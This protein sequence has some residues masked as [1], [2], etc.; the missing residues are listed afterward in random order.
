MAVV[1]SQMDTNTC[2]VR[3][4]SNPRGYRIILY[5][6]YKNITSNQFKILYKDGGFVDDI[7]VNGGGSST[8]TNTV[9]QLNITISPHHAAQDIQGWSVHKRPSGITVFTFDVVNYR[10]NVPLCLHKQGISVH[11]CSYLSFYR[12]IQWIS[13]SGA[14]RFFVQ[15]AAQCPTHGG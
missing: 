11:L 6:D 8:V 7:S 12:H 1:V 13:V 5:F 3:V 2:V 14:Q 10:D 4:V 15:Q 9:G